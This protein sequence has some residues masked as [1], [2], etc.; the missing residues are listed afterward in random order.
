MTI[1]FI[2]TEIMST[3]PIIAI[4]NTMNGNATASKVIPGTGKKT[5]KNP[6]T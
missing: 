3:A 4:G 6:F 5:I 1:G 2:W